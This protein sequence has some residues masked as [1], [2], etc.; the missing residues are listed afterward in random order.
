[1][2]A[3]VHIMKT[4]GQ[5]FRSILRQSFPGKH[6]DLIATKQ[7]SLEDIRWAQRFYPGLKSIAGHCVRPYVDLDETGLTP[8]YFTFLRDPV[9]RCA[10]HYQFSMERKPRR[11]PFEEWILTNSNYHTRM[12]SDS[13]D[14]DRAIE[15]L[16]RK[17]GFVG[18]VERFNESL[19][20][21]EQWCNDEA[22]NIQYRSINIARNNRVKQEILGNS[23][24]VALIEEFHQSDRVIDAYARNV[25][26][27]R[28]IK[29]FGPTLPAKLQEL[30][31]SLPGPTILSFELLAATAKRDMLYKPLTRYVRRAA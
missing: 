21:F 1:M 28:Q 10:S 5:T 14:A 22:L 6:C 26:Y 16:E 27:P 4:A 31:D 3:H 17:I 25:I 8:R 15:I 24:Y 30:E 19:L 29:Q 12:L 7:A 2:L 9:Q 11:V 18:L 13:E 23:N 20:L